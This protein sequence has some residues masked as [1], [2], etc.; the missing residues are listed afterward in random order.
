MAR[1]LAATAAA[2]AVFTILVL[3]GATTRIDDWAIDHVMPTL[4]PRSQGGIVHT[5]G[6]WRPKLLDVYLYPASF[7]VSALVVATL[8]TILARNGRRESALVW[9]GAWLAAN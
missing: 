7:V 8:C 4:D 5:R 9:L 6:L 3:A 1:A 2:L